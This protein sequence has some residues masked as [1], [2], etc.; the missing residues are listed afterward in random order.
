MVSSSALVACIWSCL[1]LRQL[2]PAKGQ[3]RIMAPDSL[4]GE[5]SASGGRIDG[6][7]ATFG[8]PFYGER[9][10]GQLLWGESAGKHHCTADDY[11]VPT[12]QEFMP[13]GKTYKEVRL[14]NI[15]LVERGTCSFVTKVKVAR[16][17]KAHAV[18]IVDKENSNLTAHDIRRV[19]V[20]DDGYGANV[21]IPSI[22]VSRE[23]GQK[24]IDA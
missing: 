12:P 22:L 13:P 6:S 21:D 18:I 19:I 3:V 5:L 4:V 7:T 17:K 24:L 14:I 16:Q 10:L 8:A 9:I 23:E 11:S 20:A 2:Q 1:V 15:V